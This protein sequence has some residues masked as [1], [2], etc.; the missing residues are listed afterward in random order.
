MT[1]WLCWLAHAP[2]CAAR[3]R[4]AKYAS[5]SAR[6]MRSARPRTATCR[7]IP[8]HGNSSAAFPV[9]SRSRPLRDP[10]LVKKQNPRG[11]TI[12]TSINR[13][14]GWPRPSTVARVAAFGSGSPNSTASASQVRNSSSGAPGT[15]STSNPSM[16][17][18]RYSIRCTG[19]CSTMTPVS[20]THAIGRGW[21]GGAGSRIR[22]IGENGGRPGPPTA[23]E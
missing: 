12:L 22:G 21:T 20:T 9:C 11:S 5:D 8:C 3:G 10:W 16:G 19:T 4:D 6:G 1:S 18:F 14:E 13:T 2:I 17:A 7:C 23:Q 15:L